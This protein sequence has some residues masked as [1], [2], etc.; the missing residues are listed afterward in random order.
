MTKTP[1]CPKCG[2]NRRVYADGDRFWFCT[3]CRAQFDPTD[4]GDYSDFDPSAR[5]QREEVKQ[6]RKRREAAAR[7][8]RPPGFR[9]TRR[10]DR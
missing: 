8:A 7:A 4:D 2:D 6:L 3:R 10:F 1:D 9:P 5:L